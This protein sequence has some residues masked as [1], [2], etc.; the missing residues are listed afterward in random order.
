LRYNYERTDGKE[1]YRESVYLFNEKPEDLGKPVRVGYTF[2]GWYLDAD[3]TNIYDATA[4]TGENLTLYAKWISKNGEE[5]EPDSSSDSINETPDNNSY[6]IWIV[7][8]SAVVLLAVGAV[9]I[10]AVKRKK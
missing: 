4:A 2:D 7:V 5:I 9:I 6:I 1:V 3:C 8:G 10:I